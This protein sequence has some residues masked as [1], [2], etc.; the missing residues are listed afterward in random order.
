MPDV[1][2]RG[3]VRVKVRDL[4]YLTLGLELGLGT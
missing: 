2:V 1:R 3:W 4:I